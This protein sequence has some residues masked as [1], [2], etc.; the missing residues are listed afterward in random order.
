MLRLEKKLMCF[1]WTGSLATVFEVD[2]LT[3]M[4]ECNLVTPTTDALRECTTET[5]VAEVEAPEEKGIVTYPGS[6]SFLP[7]PWLADAVISANSNTL[8]SWSQQ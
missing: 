4:A 5:K 1:L 3:L 6:A 2:L 7:A 8:S